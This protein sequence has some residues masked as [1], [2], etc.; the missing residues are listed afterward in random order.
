MACLNGGNLMGF[1]DAF[2]AVLGVANCLLRGDIVLT[3]ILWSLPR[4]SGAMQSIEPG[5]P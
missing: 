1:L 3:I 5:I 2:K 4:H